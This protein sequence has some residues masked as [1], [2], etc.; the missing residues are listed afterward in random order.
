MIIYEFEK[1]KKMSSLTLNI[2][3]EKYM[4]KPRK[5]LSIKLSLKVMKI[6][7]QFCFLR[8]VFFLF[9]FPLCQPISINFSSFDKYKTLIN[10]VCTSLKK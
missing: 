6:Q 10:T 4:K 1:L 7:S 9:Y 5:L 8:L 2:N 3:I